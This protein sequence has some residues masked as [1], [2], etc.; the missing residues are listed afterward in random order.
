MNFA[1]E[2]GGIMVILTGDVHGSFG[3]DKLTKRFFP[4]KNLTKD[5]Y[6]IVLGDFGF[7]WDVVPSRAEKYWLDFFESRPWTTLFIDGNHENFDRLKEYP[8][9]LWHG[10][11]VQK[12]GDSCIH[13]MRGQ[14]F[15]LEG[16]TFFTF[17][18]AES[19][20]KGRRIEHISWWKDE[21]PTYAQ[22]DEA[23]ENLERAENKVDYVLTHTCPRKYIY[24]IFHSKPTDP[25]NKALSE[26]MHITDFK[27][28]FFGHL[29]V[30]KELDDKFTAVYNEFF[31]VNKNSWKK[32]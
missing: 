19:Y 2:K 22:V 3:V 6:V 30:D 8:V 10:G 23:L 20:D 4:M 28:W 17:G 27:H 21:L 25:T 24:E 5:D 29:H 26:F 14:V 32:I 13:L 18:G 31:Q 16:M 15:S 11:K 7:I 1:V 9:S 12:I